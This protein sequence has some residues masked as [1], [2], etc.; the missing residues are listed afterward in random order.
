MYGV[1]GDR[2]QRQHKNHLSDFKDWD[3]L[4]HAKD[5]LLFQKN[6][7]KRLSI[8]EVA[9]SQGELYTIVTNKQ[10]KGRAGSIVAIVEGTRADKVIKCLLQMPSHIRRKV[11]E[12]TLD[13][14]PT[15]KLIAKTCFV[16]A[17]QVIDRFHVQKLAYEAVQEMR[18]KY[19]WEAIDQENQEIALS[20]QLG[21]T[22]VPHRLEN[23]DTLKQLLARSRYLL[24]KRKEL[25]TP[26]QIQRGELLFE[27]YP[28]LQIA[29]THAQELGYIYSHSKQKGIAYTRLAQWFNEVQT[30]GYKSFQTVIRTVQAH[31]DT[32]LNYF[33]R[34]ST[35]AAAE[36]FNAKIKALR[37]Q[38]RGVRNISFFL[39]RLAKIYA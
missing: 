33:D 29:Y 15:M 39:Y 23:G 32:I 27:R 28:D 26:S 38:F 25:W 2:L 19:R 16:K 9:L 8:D 20:K 30:I 17:T 22:F 36:S 18:I 7:G 31:Y 12:I 37:S 3:Q 35:N 1:R 13:M 10:A 14:A 6:I 4:A 34:R 24:F 5:W 21:K 11:K